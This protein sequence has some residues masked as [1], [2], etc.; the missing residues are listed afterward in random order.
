MTLHVWLLG[1][2][3]GPVYRAVGDFSDGRAWLAW[4]EL[5]ARPGVPHRLKNLNG[6]DALIVEDRPLTAKL[7]GDQL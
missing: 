6:T 3:Q 4:L 7:D 1:R 2:R 5:D